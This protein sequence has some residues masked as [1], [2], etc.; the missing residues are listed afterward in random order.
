MA[1]GLSLL[2]PAAVASANPPA[3]DLGRFVPASDQIISTRQIHLTRSGPAQVV[4]AFESAQTNAQG[5]QPQDLMILSWDRFAK[6]WVTVWDGAKVT[7][8]Q[9]GLA[10]GGLAYTAVFPSAAYVSNVGY[11]PITPTKGRTD[12]EFQFDYS[13][14]ANGYVEVGI[15][16]F[17]GQAAT[18]AYFDSFA[19]AAVN[20]KVIGKVPHQ[21]LSVPIGWLTAVD[22]QCCPVRT[23]VN[24]VALRKQSYPGGFRT[25]SYVVTSSTQSWLG[26]FALRPE[27]TNGT[28][29]NPVVMTVVP[30][31]P[32]AGILQVGDQLVGVAGVSAN[33]NSQINGSPVIDEV[34]KSLPGAKIALNIM[35]N[36]TPR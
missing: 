23:Y 26:V 5:K 30:G 33:P 9:T 14:G 28:W 31:G 1:T 6:R 18:M 13:F 34:A 10:S 32:A 7:S 35:R 16:H 21:E 2:P 12:L 8:P 25:S 29:P 4:V 19:P 24:T 20:P 11:R 15:V 22:P 17:D 3:P 36:E 27:Q